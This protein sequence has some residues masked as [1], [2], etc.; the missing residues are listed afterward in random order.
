MAMTTFSNI[1]SSAVSRPAKAA[2]ADCRPEGDT[3]V[4]LSSKGVAIA[5][6][7]SS[8]VLSRLRHG[9]RP[10]VSMSSLW[11]I[12][13]GSEQVV[14]A[15]WRVQ[16]Y[17][18]G[19][20][21]DVFFFT[22]MRYVAL[23][24]AF[25]VPFLLSFAD[26]GYVHDFCMSPSIIL[27][28]L[29][30]NFVYGFGT[31][32]QLRISAVDLNL[33]LE[34]V[35][36]SRILQERVSSAS[37]CMDLVSLAGT[38]WMMSPRL[39]W[40]VFFRML[41]IWRLSNTADDLYEIQ[42]ARL[43]TEK[44]VVAF[45]KLLG[46]IGMATHIFGCMWFGALTSGT[47][48]YENLLLE[49]PRYQG[50]SLVMVYLYYF[51]DGAAMLVGWGGPAPSESDGFYTEIELIVWCILAPAAAL[52]NAFVLTQLL[53]VVQQA[54][55]GT[56]KH[57]DRLA[58]AS[59]YMEPLKIPDQL[60]QRFL[61]CTSFLSVHNV[62]KQGEG[63][64]FDSMSSDILREVKINLFDNLV[65]TAP[66]FQ[67]PPASFVMEVICAFEDVV[68]TPGDLIFK[69]GDPGDELFFITYGTVHVLDHF[70]EILAIKRVGEYFGEMALVYDQPRNATCC[71]EAY[72]IL[73]KLG[74]VSFEECLDANPEVKERIIDQILGPL[75]QTSQVPQGERRMGSKGTT[76]T[77]SPYNSSSPKEDRR[78]ERMAL[79]GNDADDTTI[80]DKDAMAAMRAPRA[81]RLPS[82]PLSDRS[83]AIDAS[84]ASSL[85]TLTEEVT[86]IRQNAGFLETRFTRLESRLST[87]PFWQ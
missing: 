60:K 19:G 10:E 14:S 32:M 6:R 24:D 26:L 7:D 35:N 33:A 67:D 53:D 59:H 46:S 52:F 61:Q 68:Y 37:F 69:K 23:I 73:A 13:G 75:R 4:P 36:P 15:P 86:L 21:V 62:N 42:S 49:N 25:W 11:E 66:F 12:D 70:F 57:L 40:L 29:A 39:K 83:R 1:R 58:A 85:R 71:T 30:L 22:I 51:A 79:L 27:L 34:Y 87:Y 44:P 81:E 65:A 48:E 47:S 17:R 82:T 18:Y 38:V 8:N 50:G 63:E 2:V 84:V 16:T 78:H 20:R 80:Y 56:D 76:G 77:S 43:S 41:R 45:C 5:P 74:R 54:S 31:L 9:P 64:L 28:D 3:Y 72:C 55:A